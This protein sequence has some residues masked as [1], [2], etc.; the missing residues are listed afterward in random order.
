MSDVTPEFLNA[1][2]DKTG[3]PVWMLNGETIPEV[4]DSAR[5]AVEWKQASAPPPPPSATA[6]VPEP[7]ANRIV[8]MR[9]EAPDDWMAAWRSGLLA[10]RGAPAPPPR[11]NGESHRRAAPRPPLPAGPCAGGRGPAAQF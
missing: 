4:W 5:T 11:R 6:A 2:S 8:Q 10:G 9:G 3:V 7:S 1:V